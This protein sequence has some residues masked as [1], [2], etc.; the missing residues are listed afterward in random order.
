MKGIS[1]KIK[2]ELLVALSKEIQLL[3]NGGMRQTYIAWI[4]ETSQPFVSNM[5]KQKCINELSIDRIIDVFRR[6]G[7]SVIID[8]QK[9]TVIVF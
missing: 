4:T 5:R 9:M 2:E 7:K 6:I 8:T 1:K 3:I